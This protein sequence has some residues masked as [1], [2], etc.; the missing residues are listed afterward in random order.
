M[1]E[2]PAQSKVRP[3]LG[4][5]LLGLVLFTL[6]FTFPQKPVL[7]LDSSWRQALA[8]FLHRGFP[9]GESVVFTY[10]PMGFLLGNTYAGLYY[11]AYI[12]WQT[13]FSATAA[14]LIVALGRPLRGLSRF[15]YFAF[16]VIWGVSY[17]DALHMIFIALLGWMMLNRTAFPPPRWEGIVVGF[18]LAVMGLL[19]FTNLL[20]AGFVMV[21]VSVHH[22]LKGDRAAAI[23][24]LGAFSI[25]FLAGWMGLGQSLLAL[26]AYA[27]NSLEISSGYQAAM[28]VPTPD[29]QLG[30]AFGV[31]FGLAG[32]VAWHVW[33]QRDPIRTGARMLIFAAFIFLNWKHGFVRSDGH[34]LGFFYCALVPVVAFPVLLREEATRTW[35]PRAFLLVAGIACILGM[36]GT[37]TSN[38]DYAA[39]IT[40]NRLIERVKQFGDLSRTRSELEGQVDHWKREAK[41][42]K[43]QAMV[44]ESSLDVLG[45]EQAIALFNEFNYTPRP[46]FQSYSVYTRKLAEMNAA[47]VGSNEAPEFLLLKMQT[48]DRRPLMAD[49]SHLMALF[50]NLYTYRLTE[51]D[52]HLFERRASHPP[53]DELKP[54]LVRSLDAAVGETINLSEFGSDHIWIEIDLPFS[55]VGRI[56]KFLYKPV[57]PDLL[58]TDVTG[59]TTR[60]RIPHSLGLAGFQLN[61]HITDFTNYLEAHGGDSPVQV[62]DISI[63]IAEE[64]RFLFADSALIRLYILPS[65]EMKAEYAKQLERLNFEGFFDLPTEFAAK[66]PINRGKIGDREALILHAPSF[67]TFN[68]PGGEKLTG[69]HGYPTGAHSE[70]GMTDGAI[71]SITWVDD[72]DHRLLYERRLDPLNEPTDRGLHDFSIDVSNLPP[73]GELKF[74]IG[75]NQDPGWD[76]TAWSDVQLN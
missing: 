46:I 44:G 25:T 18:A 5:V 50:P 69:S 7:E 6:A 3:T 1:T 71:F 76:W 53:V 33:T 72:E 27:F 57:I 8:Y 40:N 19:K 23:R 62:R 54:R 9:F 14:I 17:S 48:I 60:Y 42:E 55:L 11:E 4:E 22:A 63:D 75:I 38:I 67:M 73:R 20:F 74:E 61:P 51:N 36:R 13:V 29:G 2:V 52:F 10:G 56:H 24:L 45:F 59:I 41:L 43:T 28:G 16:F 68:F 49:D 65:T 31:F 39:A 35:I 34:M 66:T 58:I 30:R 70:G 64:D 15:V 12:L 32:Y 26:P 21:V 37:F 47:F